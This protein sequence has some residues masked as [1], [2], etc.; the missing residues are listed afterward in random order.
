VKRLWRLVG[1]LI[2]IGMTAACGGGSKGGAASN[3]SNPGNPST[4]SNPSDPGNPGSGGGGNSNNPP[5]ANASE[6]DALIWDQ[7]NWS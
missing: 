5:A 2:V 1:L 3:P 4:P 6:W 7:G